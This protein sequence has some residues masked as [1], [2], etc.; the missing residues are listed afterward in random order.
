MQPDK[1]V[2]ELFSKPNEPSEEEIEKLLKEKSCSY[3]CEIIC[4]TSSEETGCEKSCK[5]TP[6]VSAEHVC[7]HAREAVKKLV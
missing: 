2:V 3:Q 6:E 7:L 1:H 4:K 5:F